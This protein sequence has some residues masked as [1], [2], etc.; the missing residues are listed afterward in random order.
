MVPY[1]DPETFLPGA[2]YHLNIRFLLAEEASWAAKGHEVAW[3]QF[4]VRFPA[5]SR[6]EIRF[7]KD[8]YSKLP[9]LS[10]R[11]EGQQAILQG[12]D[13]QVV[14]D[15]AAGVITSYRHRDQELLKAGPLENYYR[16]PT[17]FD[18]LMGNPPA[19]IHKWRSAGLDRLERTVIAFDL[20]QPEPKQIQVHVRVRLCA[21]GHEAG[22]HSAMV[23]HVYANGAITVEN[24]V[25]I[26][27]RLPYLPRVGVSLTLPRAMHLLTWFGRG[28]H[29]NYV[30]RKAGAA[31]GQ[32]ISTVAE[33]F[34]PY[35]YPGECG[36][37]EDARWL[38][39]TDQ[40]GAGL[41]FVGQ[42]QLHFDALHYTIQDLEGAHHLDALHPRRCDPAPGWPAHG[43][44]RR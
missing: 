25:S 20:L 12:A 30:D 2:E 24:H 17:D 43:C 7:E 13:F 29:E 28:P 41:L 22:I 8:R 19:S 44:R 16:A 35:V 36:G 4:P 18:L 11:N 3:E 38:A 33:Q 21:A 34:T 32:Y 31:V 23:Y 42:D 6:P 40:S 15:R 26:D 14:F 37:K 9:D 10:L 1:Q 27:E 5:V 39:L